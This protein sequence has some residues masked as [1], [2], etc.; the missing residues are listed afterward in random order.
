METAT[1]TFQ[2]ILQ[3]GSLSRIASYFL[4]VEDEQ[5]DLRAWP[6]I[7][8]TGNTCDMTVRQRY[9]NNNNNERQCWALPGALV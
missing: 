3:F 1:N 5:E 8:R 7:I 4:F 2:E 9:F 6:E